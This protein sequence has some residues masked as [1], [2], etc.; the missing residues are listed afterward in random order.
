MDNIIIIRT[1]MGSLDQAYMRPAHYIQMIC[2][3]I[4]ILPNWDSAKLGVCQIGFVGHFGWSWSFWDTP[5]I[6]IPTVLFLFGMLICTSLYI[7][8]TWEFK[9]LKTGL[10]V[11]V[12]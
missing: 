6:C 10:H 3:Q 5:K 1:C 7:T 11:I 2:G 12:W 9:G 4:G 8:Q